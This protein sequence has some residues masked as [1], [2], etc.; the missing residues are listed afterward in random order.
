MNPAVRAVILAVAK[1][2]AEKPTRVCQNSR[3]VSRYCGN[4]TKEAFITERQTCKL[5]G[6]ISAK[7]LRFSPLLPET[8]D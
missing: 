4:G 1:E 5:A 3:T 7:K 8:L 2:L 6:T